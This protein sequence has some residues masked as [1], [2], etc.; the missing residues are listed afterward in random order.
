VTTEHGLEAQLSSKVYS[1][2]L[3]LRRRRGYVAP[4]AQG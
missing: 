1:T 4:P 2:D 3:E